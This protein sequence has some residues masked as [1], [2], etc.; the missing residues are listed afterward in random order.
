LLTLFRSA[1]KQDGGVG[2]LGIYCK[3]YFTPS[4]NNKILEQMT[5]PYHKQSLIIFEVLDARIVFQSF[6]LIRIS[7]NARIVI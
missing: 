1:S 5:N 3:H 2:I 7:M 6:M 4:K